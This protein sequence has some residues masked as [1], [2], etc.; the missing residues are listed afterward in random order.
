MMA[1][2][3]GEILKYLQIKAESSDLAN[4]PQSSAGVVLWIAAPPDHIA[5]VHNVERVFGWAYM[6][7]QM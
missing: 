1:V 3:V 4:K 2:F 5:L 7:I 6:V